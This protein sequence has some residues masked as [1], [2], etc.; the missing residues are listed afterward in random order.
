M[1]DETE[2]IYEMR[3]LSIDFIAGRIDFV[4]FFS[5]IVFILGRDFDK[6][7]N[8]L[9]ILP[10]DLQQELLFYDRMTGENQLPRNPE[11]EYGQSSENYGWIDKK[12]YL[13]EFKEQFS[14]IIKV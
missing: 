6:V 7:S 2:A 11:W 14:K 12:Q 10:K 4:K 3:Q 9:D 5:T 13:K 1:N 8:Y